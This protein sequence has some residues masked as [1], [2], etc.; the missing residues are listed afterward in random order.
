MAFDPQQTPT[1]QARAA[2]TWRRYLRFWG[3]RAAADVDD[4]LR[5]HIEMRIRDYMARG[6]SEA[7][8][9]AATGQRLGDLATA[10]TE[11]LTI[12]TRRER[13]MTRAQLLDA[14][15]QDVTFALRTLGRQ[16]GWTT[17]AIVTLALGIGANTAVF[18]VVNS[19]LLHPLPYPN[20]DRVAIVFQEPNQG[21]NT[22]IHVM[23]TPRPAIVRAWR[24]GSR[25]FEAIEPYHT[26]DMTL[27]STDGGAVVHAARILS[28]FPRFA[29]IRPLTGRVFS[30][31]E[32]AE[33]APVVLL[34][35]ALWRTRYGSDTRLIGQSITLDGAPYTVI[36][37]MPE[38]FRLPRMMQ[39][40]TDVWLPLDM[41][42]EN[43]GLS[44]IGR[45]RPRQTFVAASRELDSLSARVDAE[46]K[47][48]V[49][50]KA[51]LAAP[52][53]MVNFRDSLLLLTAAVA[54]VLL[55]A[56]ANV[57]HLLLARAA[58]RQRELAI[59]AAL[60]AGR[61]RLFRQLVTE[62][63]VLAA[64]GCAGGLVIGWA[65]L[66][67]LVSLRPASLSELSM[68]RMDATTLLVTVALSAV[69]GLV[70]GVVGALQ[71]A[72]HSTHESLKAGTLS[73]SH[74]R[75]HNRLRSLLV[76][77]EMALSA[78][79][80][81]GATLLVRSVIHLQT[82]D[83]G[84]EPRGLYAVQ[85]SLPE[86]SYATPALK[87]AFFDELIARVR[88][89]PGVE[90]VTIA[91]G[92]PPSRNFLIGALEIEGEAP[93]AAGT[94]SF[95]NFNSV[96]PAYFKIMGIRLLEGTT[97]TDTTSNSH[98][99]IVNEGMAKKHWGG[100]GRTA[101]GRR[102]RVTFNGAGEWMTIVGVASDASTGGLTAEASTPMLYMP[103]GD[104]HEPSMIVRTKA[105]APPISTVRALVS[106]QD[107]RL[108]PPS[109]TDIESTMRDSIAGPRF[110]MLLL[111]TFT[112]LALVLAAVGLYGVMS[113]AVTQRTREIGIRIAL[114]ATRRHIARAVV[115][116]GVV[117]AACGIVIGLVSAHWA[118]KLIEKMLYGIPRT[119]PASFVA[120][121]L[122]L[123]G[124]ALLACLVP[125]RRAVAVDPLIA[126]RTE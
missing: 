77:S 123:L 69:T 57:A 119:D 75:R 37:V 81:V 104:Q 64:T 46:Q 6:M 83:P 47:S 108:P 63:L 52:S 36:G 122:L 88:A 96:Q 76:V 109:V 56:C 3:P 91:A 67:V 17:I 43:V 50:F 95:L 98:Q 8:A 107:N 20:A 71:S 68:A 85:V 40:L 80:L 10:R 29:G 84:F 21:N 116:Q 65:G 38:A 19:L 120:G 1:P 9:R 118:T 115:G 93:P 25:S 105:G 114:G 124:T 7:D 117:H 13:R 30:E 125:T 60:G 24:E 62:S 113:Y 87:R 4:E 49:R 16:K 110:T 101:L 90:G 99:L 2:F 74:T 23:V 39:D 42:Y 82:K 33:K 92:A 121:S 126:M 51:K 86:K 66:R 78:T 61:P 53:E 14:F 32:V 22:G 28:T 27:R 54:L 12:T 18:S 79:L 35:E 94:T 103:L 58:A 59:R 34:G 106:A 15:V 70:F 97:F 72:R 26:T 102:V 100:R 48:T 55:I 11:C 44:T 112:A 31:A 89:M 73:A 41:H 45:L 5:F 111:T